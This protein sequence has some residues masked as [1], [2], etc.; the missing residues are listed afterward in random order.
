MFAAQITV[1]TPLPG[2]RLRDRLK[3]E[4]RLLKK[5]WKNYT[6]YDVNFIPKNMTPH[7]LQKGLLKTHKLI[8]N[9]DVLFEQLKY[10]K[11]IYKRD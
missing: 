7:Q 8:H 4:S 11:E 2:T 3:N 5:T 6:F 1:L 9:K 10:F